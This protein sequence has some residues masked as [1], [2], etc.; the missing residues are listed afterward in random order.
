[1]TTWEKIEKLGYKVTVNQ[2]ITNGRKVIKSYKAKKGSYSYSSK[3]ITGLYNLIRS[4][5]LTIKN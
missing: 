5:N 3:S 1:M 4:K 2:E